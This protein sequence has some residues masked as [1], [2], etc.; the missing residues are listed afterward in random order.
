MQALS[1]NLKCSVAAVETQT[2]VVAVAVAVSFDVEIVEGFREGM[3]DRFV[4]VD[5]A[6]DSSKESEEILTII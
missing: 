6:S 3:F 1:E 4:G 2:V 5:Y